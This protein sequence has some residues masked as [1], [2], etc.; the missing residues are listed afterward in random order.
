[1]TLIDM[2]IENPYRV[3]VAEE[4]RAMISMERKSIEIV[5]ID[6]M[7][8]ISIL[9]KQKYC[10]YLRQYVLNINYFNKGGN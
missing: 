3:L 7:F 8:I 1:M 10:I 5:F 6:F 2:N 4:I 9:T